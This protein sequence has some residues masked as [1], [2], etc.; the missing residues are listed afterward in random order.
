MD[1]NKWCRRSRDEDP[2]LVEE[3]IERVELSVCGE[4]DAGTQG[5][6]QRRGNALVDGV[7]C[8]VYQEEG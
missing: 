5:V 7:F 3:V 1:S 4:R 2:D 6:E 8:D